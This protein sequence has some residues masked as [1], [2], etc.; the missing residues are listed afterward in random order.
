MSEVL[1][2]EDIRIIFIGTSSDYSLACLDAI[3]KDGFE[4]VGLIDSYRRKK[5]YTRWDKRM[6]LKSQLR[7][8]GNENRIPVIAT[9]NMNS[10]EAEHFIREKGTNLICV[11]SACQLLKENIINIPFYG[12]MNAHG[13]LLPD[14]RGADPTYWIFL[15]HEQEGGVTLHYID[16]GEDTGDIITQKKFQIPFGMSSVEYHEEETKAA[17]DAYREALNSLVSRT[18]ERKRQ[19]DSSHPQARNVTRDDFLLEYEQMEVENVYHFLMGT[20]GISQIYT[21]WLYSYDIYE[22]KKGSFVSI[23]KYDIRCK[24][25]IVCVRRRIVPVSAIKKL[26]KT[27]MMTF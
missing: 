6:V 8:Y 10:S 11:A 21:G 24:D 16:I 7:K 18:I 23:G 22:Y 9:D 5:R 12:V 26:L 17:V 4:V 1:R 20:D 13:A 2:K 14:Y 19:G 27:I 15:N 3:R 25:G